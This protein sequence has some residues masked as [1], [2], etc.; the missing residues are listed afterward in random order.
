M[1][2]LNSHRGAVAAAVIVIALSVL[3]GFH[4]VA[5]NSKIIS[6]MMSDMLNGICITDQLYISRMIRLLL[7]FY[8]FFYKGYLF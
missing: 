1:K 5:G 6:C 8:H 4:I 7:P 3:F 2:V